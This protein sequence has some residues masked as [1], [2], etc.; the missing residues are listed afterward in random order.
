VE[1]FLPH[2]LLLSK[3]ADVVARKGD[4]FVVVEVEYL[5]VEGNIERV[6]GDVL[7][8]ILS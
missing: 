3:Y 4:D 1:A 5:M 7:V 8:G 6:V 2:R